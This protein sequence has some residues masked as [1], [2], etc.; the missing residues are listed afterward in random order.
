MHILFKRTDELIHKID[1]FM[2]LV[3]E[4]SLHFQKALFLLLDGRMDEFDVSFETVVKVENAADELKKDI[5]GKLYTQMLI[6]ESR[7]DVLNIIETMDRIV[8]GTKY[9]IKN[10]SI[11]RPEIPENIIVGIKEL[12]EPVCK[13]VES[14]VFSARA[15]FSDVNAIKNYLHL[16]KHYEKE[17][18]VISEKIKRNIFA[19]DVYLSNKL[20]MRD[21]V[22]KI[23]SL[24]D[25]SLNVADL[26]TIAAIKLRV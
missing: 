9:I 8:N 13:A 18:D 4:A 23:D 11:E 1:Q 2:D 14:L 17:A 10:L 5:E 15:Y 21:I 3:K 25:M 16:V 20:Q 26:I 24:A 22:S 7:G 12:S 19:L 6:P